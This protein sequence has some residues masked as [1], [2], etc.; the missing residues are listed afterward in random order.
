MSF[1]IPS[2]IAGPITQVDD[3][4]Q[5]PLG[6]LYDETPATGTPSGIETADGLGGRTWRYVYNDDA[7]TNWSEGNPIVM[8]S[9]KG[10]GFG[11]QSTTST[12]SGYQC[13]GVAQHTIAAGKYGWILADGIG[14]V[15]ADSDTIDADETIWISDNAAGRARNEGAVTIAAAGANAPIGWALEDAADGALATCVIRLPNV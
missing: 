4:P 10:P 5:Y 14:E 3:T 13:I 12:L 8:E 15:L 7:A 11:R 2:A 9:A 6:A 1:R